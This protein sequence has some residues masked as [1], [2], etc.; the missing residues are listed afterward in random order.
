MPLKKRARTPEST[1]TP[2]WSSSQKAEQAV[3]NR[4]VKLVVTARTRLTRKARSATGEPGIAMSKSAI[5]TSVGARPRVRKWYVARPRSP[6][7][8]HGTSPTG[9]YRSLATSPVRIRSARS[10]VVPPPHN[11]TVISSAWPIQT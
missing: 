8:Y 10:S 1:F 11:A 9:R 5:P 4:I 2:L 7:R 3:R 6:A